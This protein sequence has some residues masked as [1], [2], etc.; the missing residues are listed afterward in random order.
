M[1]RFAIQ[2]FATR[3]MTRTPAVPSKAP[4]VIVGA[5]LAGLTVALHVAQSHPVVVL[6]KRELEEGATAWAQGGIVG[7]LGEDDSVESHVRDTQD[8]GAGLVDEN[9]ARFIA[10]HSAE[11]VEWLV[12]RGVP[13]SADPDGPL[14][15]HLTRE[16]GH[17]VRRIAHAAD[18][19]GKAIHD[20]LLAAVREHPNIRLRERWMALDLITTRHLKIQAAPRC[21]G[22]YA[23]DIDHQRVETLP[24]LAVV[25]ATGG[26]GK[27]Y[28]Y[29]TNP[30]T[31]TGDG[32]AMAWRAGCRIGNME[33]IQFH[34]TCLYHPQERTFLISEALRGEGAHLLLPDGTRFMGAHDPRLELAPRDIV[35]RAIDFEMKKHGVD[36]V[37][38]DATHLGEAFLRSHFPTIH[39]RCMSLGIDIARE[40]I[41]VVPAAHYTCGGVVTDLH[42]RTDLPG[43]YGVGE[44][45]YTGL[46]GANRLASNSLL[47]CVV[48][49]QTCARSLLA[50]GAPETRALPPW[51]ESQVEDADE[52]VVIAHNWDELRLVMWNYV[53]IVRTTKRLAR[54]LHRIKLLRSEIDDYYANFR[55]NRDLLELRNLVDCAELIVRSA[56]MRHES[57]GL[58]FS[59][60]FPHTLPVSFPTVLFLP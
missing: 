53:G 39:A 60:D 38:L 57:R 3:L 45:T 33:F 44:T 1:K 19:T 4:V 50:Q 43:L 16:G 55:V 20:V 59:R 27:V 25:L 41:P 15:L 23:L 36:N 48:F 52:Q 22:V 9:T 56:L 54:A 47:E 26:A 40:P 12:S 11:A 13:F 42:G 32:I 49:G 58:H 35:A 51:D 7:V 21:Y 17:A 34:P 8:A 2:L 24:A 30:D 29:T 10:E 6:A 31:S 28:R 46:H 18:A 37:L 14:G 5:G